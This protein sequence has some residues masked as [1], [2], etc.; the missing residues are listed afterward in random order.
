[1]I[2]AKLIDPLATL[3]DFVE[4]NSMEFVPG[5]NLA[6]VIRLFDAQSGV[7]YIPPS[8]AIV[9]LTF[10]NND[11]TELEVTAT[12]LD[13]DDRSMWTTPLT[14]AQSLILG[15]PNVRVKLDV[16]GDATLIHLALI[17]NA[18][19]RVTTVGDC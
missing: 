16:V 14:Q 18:L 17:Q 5:E 9:T 11:E 3:N 1:M 10:V 8:T 19:I 7:R 2:R 4:L 13:P 15:A 6:V 12:L